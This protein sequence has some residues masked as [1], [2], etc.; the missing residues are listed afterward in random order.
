MRKE[1]VELSI[2]RHKAAMRGSAVSLTARTA[3]RISSGRTHLAATLVKNADVDVIVFKTGN[4]LPYDP[5]NRAFSDS[6]E[7]RTKSL[8]DFSLSVKTHIAHGG[9]IAEWGDP[10]SG[11]D[12][13]KLRSLRATARG[14]DPDA[15]DA[16]G[17]M[18]VQEGTPWQRLTTRVRRAVKKGKRRLADAADSAAERIEARV[19][20]KPDKTRRRE[21]GKLRGRIADAADRAADRIDSF[22][23]RAADR[24][25]RAA[26]RIDGGD[27]DAKPKK[28]KKNRR[29]F[30]QYAVGYTDEERRAMEAEGTEKPKAPKP[31]KADEVD[32]PEIPVDEDGKPEAP[33]PAKPLPE[34]DE[35]EWAKAFE[36]WKKTSGATEDVAAD[37]TAESKMPGKKYGTGTKDRDAA[38]IGARDASKKNKDK[39]LH[40]V[41]GT[42]GKYRIVDDER[43]E[44]M[45]G[46]PVAAYKDGKIVMRDGAPVKKGKSSTTLKDIDAAGGWSGGGKFANEETAVSQA[47][48]IKNTVYPGKD[49]GPDD[50]IH[51]VQ[52]EGGQFTL[53][54]DEKLEALGVDPVASFNGDGKEVPWGATTPKPKKAKKE[55]KPKAVGEI[56]G[57]EPMPTLDEVTPKPEVVE[58]AKKKTPKLGGKQFGRPFKNEKS[59]RKRADELAKDGGTYHVV[60]TEQ[61]FRVVDQ[62]R[63]DSM[64]V[65]PVHTGGKFVA[66]PGVKP[67]PA[68]DKPETTEAPEPPKAKPTKEQVWEKLN[69][70][71]VGNSGVLNDT[72]SGKYSKDELAAQ[73]K[74]HED[75]VKV[76]E[77]LS[78]DEKEALGDDY[79]AELQG[80][81]NNVAIVKAAI[82]E[83]DGD[84]DAAVDAFWDAQSGKKPSSSK[85]PKKAKPEP[86]KPLPKDESPMWVNPET[87]VIMDP[88]ESM[89]KWIAEKG[90]TVADMGGV[91]VRDAAK[92][93]FKE[94]EYYLKEFA[95]DMKP[96]GKSEGKDKDALLDSLSEVAMTSLEPA[97]MDAADILIDLI[98]SEGLTDLSPKKIK[99]VA[100]TYAAAAKKKIS[101]MNE[102]E[103]VGEGKETLVEAGDTSTDALETLTNTLKDVVDGDDSPED[104]IDKLWAL[105]SSVDD[106]AADLKVE[107]DAGDEKS[108]QKLAAAKK[109]SDDIY[110]LIEDEAIKADDIKL[111]SQEGEYAD[112]RDL[113]ATLKE[114]FEES[115]HLSWPDEKKE[116][117]LKKLGEVEE[118]LHELD[119]DS[120]IYGDEPWDIFSELNQMGVDIVNGSQTSP[121]AGTGSGDAPEKLPG[122]SVS[123]AQVDSHYD[124]QVEQV[125]KDIASGK[126][127]KAD[128]EKKKAKIAQERAK[129]ILDLPP[130]QVTP[131]DPKPFKTSREVDPADAE[132][133]VPQGDMEKFLKEAK[134]DLVSY[135]FEKGFLNKDLGEYKEITLPDGTKKDVMVPKP[136]ITDEDI[137]ASFVSVMKEKIEFGADP[138]ELAAGRTNLHNF[139]V[140]AG[141]GSYDADVSPDMSVYDRFNHLGPS[142]Q[143]GIVAKIY[144]YPDAF[145]EDEVKKVFSE[146]AK[147]KIKKNTKKDIQSIKDEVT[148]PEKPQAAT[149]GKS[150]VASDVEAVKA[151]G[152]NVWDEFVEKMPEGSILGVVEDY[153]AEMARYSAG[154]VPPFKGSHAELITFQTDDDGGKKVGYWVDQKY[155]TGELGDKTEEMFPTLYKYPDSEPGSDNYLEPG[156]RGG[157]IGGP[158]IYGDYSPAEDSP[159]AGK[160]AGS[161]GD[162]R[163]MQKI[164]EIAD[165]MFGPPGMNLDV[166]P[167]PGSEHAR[168]IASRLRERFGIQGGVLVRDSDGALHYIRRE[169]WKSVSTEDKQSGFIVEMDVKPVWKTWADNDGYGGN[170]Y[171]KSLPEGWKDL[172]QEDREELLKALLS[173]ESL[174]S[175]GDL[176]KWDLQQTGLV[177]SEYDMFV[178]DFD[179]IDG[180][181]KV[182]QLKNWITEI[183]D[184]PNHPRYNDTFGIY[185]VSVG[186]KKIFLRL[187]EGMELIAKEHPSLFKK[188][189]EYKGGG[190]YDDNI[191]LSESGTKK[192]LASISDGNTDWMDGDDI[193]KTQM[194]Q[195]AQEWMEKLGNKNMGGVQL[196][197]EDSDKRMEDIRTTITTVLKNAGYEG[198]I[199]DVSEEVLNKALEEAGVD[200]TAFMVK[201]RATAMRRAITRQWIAAEQMAASDSAE[202]MVEFNKKLQ[203]GQFKKPSDLDGDISQIEMQITEAVKQMES[204]NPEAGVTQGSS[205]YV[206]ARARLKLLQRDLEEMKKA[207]QTFLTDMYEGKVPMKIGGE[208][209]LPP[210]GSVY[211]KGEHSLESATMAANA[212]SPFLNAGQQIGLFQT[213]DGKYALVD[214]DAALN[215]DMPAP[216]MIFT[217]HAKT[218]PMEADPTD[219]MD[220][221]TAAGTP[222]VKEGYA[223]IENLGVSSDNGIAIGKHVESGLP[224][225]ATPEQVAAEAAKWDDHIT[226]GGSLADVPN[227]LLMEAIWRHREGGP[228]TGRFKFLDKAHGYNDK[229]GDLK[230]RTH[231]FLDTATGHVFVIKSAERNDQEGVRELFGNLVMQSLGFPSSGGRTASVPWKAPNKYAN[232]S[233]PEADAEAPQVSV[234]L[235]SAEMLYEGKS[236]GHTRSMPYEQKAD[237]ISRLTPESVAT[238]VVMD[239]LFRYYDRQGDNWVA[240]ENPDGS[241]SY[242]PIDHGNAFG[243]FKGK[244]FVDKD[245][246]VSHDNSP[247]YEDQLGMTFVGFDG[248]GVWK[249]A[250]QSMTTPE[251]RMRFAEATLRAVE[252]A[253]ATDYELEAEKLISAQKLD[254][255]LAERARTSAKQIEQKKQKLDSYVDPM[256]RELGMSDDE[257]AQARATVQAEISGGLLKAGKAT[258]PVA[259]P[260]ATEQ[261]MTSPTPIAGEEAFGNAP[262]LPGAIT[263]TDALAN[264]SAKT[265]SDRFVSVGGG[266]VKGGVRFRSIDSADG[267][268]HVLMTMRVDDATAQGIQKSIASGMDASGNEVTVLGAGNGLVLPE[269]SSTPGSKG[270]FEISPNSQ[271]TGSIPKGLTKLS[272]SGKYSVAKTSEG[273]IIVVSTGSDGYAYSLGDTIQV[274]MAPKADGSQHSPAEVEALMR[275]VGIKN[276]GYT[277]DG[278]WK[279]QAGELLAR[280]WDGVDKQKQQDPLAV[281]LA[282]VAANRGLTVNDV[283]PYFDSMGRM[284]FRLT[285]EAWEKVK[286]DNPKLK[287]SAHLVVKTIGHYNDESN[288]TRMVRSGGFISKAEQVHGGAGGVVSYGEGSGGSGASAESDL[289]SG[290]GKGVFMTP[291]PL[292]GRPHSSTWGTRG[293]DVVFDGEEMLRDLGWWAHGPNDGPYGALNPKSSHMN[294]VPLG[295]DNAD[296]LVKE[297][298]FEFLP[299]SAAELGKAK[300]IILHGGGSGIAR[301]K[302]II[303]ALEAEGVTEINGI[304]LDK[305]FIITAQDAREAF[306]DY[307]GK[308][309]LGFSVAPK[310]GSPEAVAA[311]QAAQAQADSLVPIW[312]T[313]GYSSNKEYM[314]DGGMQK[315]AKIN[316]ARNRARKWTMAKPDERIYMYMDENG[317]YRL[318]RGKM[319]QRIKNYK[320]GKIIASFKNGKMEDAELDLT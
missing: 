316:V 92:D 296:Q 43:L 252:R 216:E 54:D 91:S 82:D 227:D 146:A 292:K 278:E 198:E 120:N 318:A 74:V 273:H 81:K 191:T 242:H 41:K 210:Q 87:G 122:G 152:G 88:A 237:V 209:Y 78:P 214:M 119:G 157:L 102:K 114:S 65:E 6:V 181:E 149:T 269:L 303:E 293:T 219:M 121:K 12:V 175:F 163:H 239:S 140:M 16:D 197:L 40:V 164:G 57:E 150:K 246:N 42:D 53:V 315:T 276:T 262:A 46:K 173:Q 179:D 256:L 306:P 145:D 26:E 212:I 55:K 228:G 166:I 235:E 231:R 310:P 10:V 229:S 261:K 257:I 184:N 25:D 1:R 201:L 189:A 24:L 245:G 178:P 291:I 169:D 301:K 283:E 313:K 37:A 72:T 248:E 206:G 38:L 48:N 158:T 86:K 207:R 96:G 33:S 165:Y 79:D 260:G 204:A 314:A 107:A 240:I 128:G 217:S 75:A 320:K 305:F 192:L 44:A 94:V 62:D 141:L 34:D 113:M 183:A 274:I 194:F 168:H 18:L 68:P 14:F 177:S 50:N 224:P 51:V 282:R 230:K 196:E 174:F 95:D 171:T 39:T 265:G 97:E 221:L 236:L 100:K 66:A 187:D 226:N 103:M 111:Q 185:E 9:M 126:I 220:L 32:K 136:G 29:N 89:D 297:K 115:D 69:D 202:R 270:Q 232:F 2:L 127:S 162:P 308:D 83:Y 259:Q 153:D 286:A 284:R 20:A 109:M 170:P 172:S 302:K 180:S 312:V 132:A 125:N 300:G 73:L 19:D 118:T 160:T 268:R 203:N 123:K 238:G 117:W 28:P 285:D 266:Q 193:D 156:K 134:E 161:W 218:G 110:G 281:R 225:D 27:V 190:L 200:P 155:F 59:A 182:A 271:S 36:E 233:H 247:E 61:G 17:D 279:M 77:S 129:A 58:D 22:T 47:S 288:I 195:I 234:L 148:P 45:G 244:K 105:K 277:G 116:F 31:P 289:E 208:E 101:S 76:L 8:E 70:G 15:T 5:Q 264:A 56:P 317:H 143:K 307:E 223:G 139:D 80:A 280:T 23:D 251:R 135:L 104:K 287:D 137:R 21:R 3:G 215:A 241:V 64:G 67:E 258:K 112:L 222:K 272:G 71:P 99:E 144:S 63:L 30:R 167:E 106:Y 309:I 7:T 52:I 304:P 11:I 263:V 294:S 98:A 186:D 124:S 85:K 35:D 295:H 249:V 205:D 250:Q 253:K 319:A 267:Q 298:V 108:K 138:G 13:K 275:S 176:K 159:I 254:G 93:H 290:G 151:S 243:L 84:L 213:A 133:I 255:K 130:Q 311:A 60:S 147:K 90:P 49:F 4:V 211:L 199:S 188:V 142:S 154:E 131:D 299:D